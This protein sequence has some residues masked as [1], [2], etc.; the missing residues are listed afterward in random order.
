MIA[1]SVMGTFMFTMYYV[2]VKNSIHVLFVPN[3]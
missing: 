1:C 2:Y 3:E